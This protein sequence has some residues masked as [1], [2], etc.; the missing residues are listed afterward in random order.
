MKKFLTVSDLEQQDDRASIWALNGSARSDVGQAGELNIGIPKINGT[1][2]DHLH[3]PQTWL[4]QNLTDKIPRAQLLA[5]SEFRN[6]VNAR[7][8]VLVSSEHAEKINAQEGADEE[9]ELLAARAREI[10]E[11][12]AARAVTQAGTEI[13]NTQDMLNN[14]EPSET[15]KDAVDMAFKNFVDALSNKTD[16]EAINALRSRGKITKRELKYLSKNLKDK[17]KT[18][19]FLANL[20]N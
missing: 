10:R 3:L 18:S 2:I 7:L 19:K 15:K 9:R 4:A 20:T 12:T 17:P 6:A 14:V 16:I 11:A 5:S 8:L 13:L 1:K